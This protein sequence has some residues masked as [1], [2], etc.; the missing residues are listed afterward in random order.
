MGQKAHVANPPWSAVSDTGVRTGAMHTRVAQLTALP[1]MPDREG[2]P[3]READLS[4]TTVTLSPLSTEEALAFLGPYR[5]RAGDASTLDIL[6][7]AIAKNKARLFDVSGFLAWMAPDGEDVANQLDIREFASREQIRPFHWLF[8]VPVADQ[9]R[10][11][12]ESLPIGSTTLDPVARLT[13]VALRHTFPARSPRAYHAGGWLLGQWDHQWVSAPP[14]DHVAII[15]PAQSGRSTALRWL[16]TQWAID[17]P[18][19]HGLLID[20][21]PTAS[22]LLWSRVMGP[23]IWIPPEGMPV[24]NACG[25]TPGVDRQ[26]TVDW[27]LEAANWISLTYG[28]EPLP[29]SIRELLSATIT[30]FYEARGL[31]ADPSTWVVQNPLAWHAESKG[32]PTI[33]ELTEHLATLAPL[34]RFMPVW[35]E[36][37][38]GPLKPWAGPAEPV[39]EPG[40]LT[41][42]HVGAWLVA[43]PTLRPLWDR[44]VPYWIRAMKAAT[45]TLAWVGMDDPAGEATL[46][47]GL[48]AA[49]VRDDTGRASLRADAVW[50]MSG[51]SSAWLSPGE[52]QAI[53]SLGASLWMA[54]SWRHPVH[55]GAPV[56][57]APLVLGVSD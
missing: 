56:S 7:R 6:Y 37:W 36:A 29:L 16:L 51:T 34:E 25:L 41:T 47:V 40:H 31:T 35:E 53:W 39:D 26:D 44:W 49:V 30:A 23:T 52:R 5:G 50:A 42:V 20:G 9:D 19:A 22:G 24:W 3:G 14:V 17:K 28:G 45:P 4:R 18:D 15:G 46:P 57:W 32:M 8:R 13:S 1:W 10:V 43:Q 27:L 11:Y 38:R 54:A 33:A 21:T 48:R 55:V 12:R 2:M